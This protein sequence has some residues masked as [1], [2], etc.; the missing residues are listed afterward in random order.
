VAAMIGHQREEYMDDNIISIVPP[1]GG[2]ILLALAMTINIKIIYNIIIYPTC[3]I[4]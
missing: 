2:N 4:V 3:L 1:Q